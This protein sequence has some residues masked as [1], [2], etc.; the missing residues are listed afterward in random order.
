MVSGLRIDILPDSSV[1]RCA[2]YW[3]GVGVNSMCTRC[4]VVPEEDWFRIQ[5]MFVQDAV[6]S[7]DRLTIDH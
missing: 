6:I 1:F 2:I 3:S 4:A 7:L 5:T